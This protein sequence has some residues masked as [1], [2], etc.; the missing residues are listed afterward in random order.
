VEQEETQRIDDPTSL[1]TDETRRTGWIMLWIWLFLIAWH[2][3]G[4]FL[5][6]YE[7]GEW[8]GLALAVGGVCLA[9]SQLQRRN[10]KVWITL[11][12]IG[13]GLSLVRPL[14]KIVSYLT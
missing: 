6:G 11:A 9:M 7:R 12:F 5:F 2:V 8:S 13:I 1:P 4:C 14:L 10:Y 3:V